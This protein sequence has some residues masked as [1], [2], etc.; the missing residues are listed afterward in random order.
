MRL[1]KDKMSS[2]HAFQ[3]WN[4]L[5]KKIL[6]QENYWPFIFAKI[7]INNGKRYQ[8]F[9]FMSFICFNRAFLLIKCTQNI[10]GIRRK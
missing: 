4:N 2:G 7:S 9:F 1:K 8:F 6:D 10:V 3:N 5:S